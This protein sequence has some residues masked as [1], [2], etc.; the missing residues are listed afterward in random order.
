MLSI[1]IT[2]YNEKELLTEC[3]NSINIQ[4]VLPTN[5]LIYDDNSKFKASDY[6]LSSLNF[7]IEIFYNE[8]NKGPGYGRNFLMQKAS[9]EYIRFHDADDLLKPNAV[10]HILEKIEENKPDVIFNEIE[11]QKNGVV[12]SEKVMNFEIL[13]DLTKDSLLEYSILGSILIPSITYKRNIGLK[14]GG[15]LA[16]DT[17]KQSEDYEFHIRIINEI[18]KFEFIYD[19]L[20]IQRLRNNSHSAR[21]IKDVYVSGVLALINLADKLPD[22]FRTCISK[23]IGECAHLLFIN[24]FFNE[25]K[26]AYMISIKIKKVKYNRSRL[27]NLFALILGP[28]NTELINIYYKKVIKVD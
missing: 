14:L 15:F 13:K 23:K 26:W 28:Y 17:L 19:S 3:L 11:C 16:I 9:T 6:I 2:Y 7:P 8:E 20:V 10:K 27:F 18:E 24:Q 5:V 12:V 1:L 4:S 25:S 21:N 22:K